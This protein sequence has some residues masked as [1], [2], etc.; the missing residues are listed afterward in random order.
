M[1][2]KERIRQEIERRMLDDY[3]G[4]DSEQNETAQGVC[5]GL[6]AFIDSIR[7]ET[8]HDLEAEIARHFAAWQ[9]KQDDELLIIAHFDGVQSGKEAERMEMMKQA[10]EIKI[11]RD[12]LYALKPL[13]HERYLDYK[14]GDKVKLIILKD[15]D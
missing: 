9:K 13:I 8:D 3:N 5:A 6:L 2:D 10:V 4:P 11:N 12:T 15:D 14:I 7:A 1:T